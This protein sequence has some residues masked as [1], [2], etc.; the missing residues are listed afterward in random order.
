MTTD[1]VCG[2]TIDKAKA[3]A[4]AVHQGNTYMFCSEACK[5]QFLQDPAKYSGSGPAGHE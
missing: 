3:A 4:T 1:P 2:M 5:A